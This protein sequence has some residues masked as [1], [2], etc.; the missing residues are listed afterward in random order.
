MVTGSRRGRRGASTLGCLVAVLL[1]MAVL[2]YGVDIGRVYWSY[3]R[4][5]DEMETSARF[6]QTQPDD[7][8]QKHLIGIA[9]DLSLPAEA[10]R[11]TIKRTEHPPIV[12]IRTKYSV[13]IDLPFKRKRLTLTP[14][15][16]V[17]Q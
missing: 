17:R 7:Q 8:I 9:Q 3:Y 11:F 15:V 6:A 4:L 13:D 12:T 1:F 5:V 2:Y 14:M 16:E 10:Q